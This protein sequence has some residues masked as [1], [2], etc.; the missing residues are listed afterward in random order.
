MRFGVLSVLEL[1]FLCHSFIFLHVR[2]LKIIPVL[3]LDNLKIFQ[4]SGL[5]SSNGCS[6][7]FLFPLW[8][9]Q[10]WYCISYKN[11]FISLH[12]Q[13]KPNHVPTYQGSMQ[14]CKI[15]LRRSNFPLEPR[16]TPLALYRILRHPSDT[17]FWRC[18]TTY[19]SRVHTVSSN[20]N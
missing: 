12:S 13:I 10:T 19:S 11:L 1:S 3:N 14:R 7:S 15:C 9:L 5:A 4:E 17:I 20:C 8:I 6:K 18:N 16:V 2:H